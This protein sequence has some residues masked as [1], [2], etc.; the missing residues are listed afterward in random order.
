MA[1]QSAER[2]VA[3]NRRARFD[4]HIEDTLEAGLV[5]TGTEVK[6][7]RAGRASIQEAY[8][9]IENGEVWLYHM[10]IPPY[11]AGSIFN[12]DPLRRRKLLLHRHEI[13]RLAGKVSQK[14]YTLI[15]LRVYFSRGMAKVELALARGKRQYDRRAAIEEREAARRIARALRRR[16]PAPGGRA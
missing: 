6:S 15:P 2:V 4:Y 11:E 12:H 13:R 14:G 1:T 10:H 9:R 5:L 7:L 8:A 16:G 3:T